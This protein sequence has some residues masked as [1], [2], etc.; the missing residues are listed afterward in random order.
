M[1]QLKKEIPLQTLTKREEL[2]KG[3][4]RKMAGG[5]MRSMLGLLKDCICMV[6]TGTKYTSM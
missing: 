1:T 5:Q 3:D 6:R 2:K 4:L